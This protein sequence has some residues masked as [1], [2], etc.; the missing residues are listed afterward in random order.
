MTQITRNAGGTPAFRALR[1]RNQRLHRVRNV[2]RQILLRGQPGRSLL[3]QVEHANIRGVREQGLLGSVG[4]CETKLA[5]GRY[6]PRVDLEPLL[7]RVPASTLV[8]IDETYI[9]YTGPM[10]HSKNSPSRGRTS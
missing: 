6:I 4:A 8:W 3:A 10:N 9:D 5:T 1:P 7:R 2:R